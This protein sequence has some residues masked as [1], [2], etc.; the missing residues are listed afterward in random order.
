MLYIGWGGRHYLVREDR[1]I[2]FCND[3]NAGIE[4][5][6]GKTGGWSLLRSG[7]EKIRVTGF[8]QVPPE[9]ADYLLHK[10]VQ[11]R[12]VKVDKPTVVDGLAGTK[13]FYTPVALDRGTSAGL[14]AGMSLHVIEPSQCRGAI[15]ITAEGLDDSHGVLEQDAI[16]RARPTAGWR[17]STREPGHDL[18]IPPGRSG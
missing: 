6:D 2:D 4:P 10:P 18:G 8:P 17:V 7:D 16:D 11:A 14:R 1:V 3:V 5:R 12:V 13:Y 15:T 9:Y